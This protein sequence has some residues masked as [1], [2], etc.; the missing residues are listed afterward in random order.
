MEAGNYIVVQH[1]TKRNK[2]KRSGWKV[3]FYRGMSLSSITRLHQLQKALANPSMSSSSKKRIRRDLRY[4]TIFQELP[5]RRFLL[6]YQKLITLVLGV[7]ISNQLGYVIQVYEDRCLSRGPVEAVKFFKELYDILLRISTSNTFSVPDYMKVNSRGEPSVLGPLLELAHGSLEER[8]AALHSILIIK[9]VRCW[10]DSIST[11]SI[12]G[13]CVIPMSSTDDLPKVGNYFKRFISINGSSYDGVDLNLLCDCYE[14]SL[15]VAFPNRYT[16]D[17]LERIAELSSIHISSKSGPNGPGLVTAVL[18]HS[19]LTDLKSGEHKLYNHISD[20]AELTKNKELKFLLKEF[21]ADPYTWTNSKS[22]RPINSRLS[23]KEESW[24]KRRLFAILDYFSQSSLKGFH[25]FLFEWLKA[26]KEDG[27]FDQDKVSNVVRDWTANSE[28]SESAD[29]SKATDRIPV[30]VQSEIVARIA[31]T[32]FAKLWRCI[33]TDRDFQVSNSVDT[34]RY[35]TGQ[36]MGILSSWAMLSV[37]HHIMCRTCLAYLKISRDEATRYVVIGDDVALNGTNLFSIYRV[38]VEVLQGVGISKAKGFHMETQTEDNPIP[39]DTY[40]GKSYTAELA[41]RVF[42]NGREITVVPPDEVFTSLGSPSQMPDL[43]ASL[44]KRGYLVSDDH[45]FLPGLAS[46]CL[47]KKQALLLM[48]N[49]L[50]DAPIKGVTPAA[51]DQAPWNRLYWYQPGFN[52]EHFKM[53][54]IKVLR[55]QLIAVLS[56]TLVAVNDFIRYSL[57]N[58]GTNVKAW[59]YDSEAQAFLL[60]LIALHII[61]KLEKAV[62]KS[63]DL[64]SKGRPLQWDTFK[65]YLKDLQVVFEIGDILQDKPK[66]KHLDQQPFINTIIYKVIKESI[67]VDE[68]HRLKP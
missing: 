11:E 37:W 16:R 53:S 41:K 1:P 33:C 6:K 29:L 38:L 7:N 19:S 48:T 22:K 17:R 24:A 5:Y 58:E 20:M 52:V 28:E 43:L 35:K 2:S 55:G 63:D 4:A 59:C 8:R 40:S 31:G 54:F 68:D 67:K 45:A 30:E 56:R 62:A 49:P 61:E 42:C 65:E 13:E 23:I 25:T 66:P 50:S 60:T 15:E 32:K 46:L 51:M 3:H 57:K 36:P 12:I 26:Q 34:V 10:D 18:D 64:F 44:Q 27:T 21:E 14:R 9:L 39:S 47:H